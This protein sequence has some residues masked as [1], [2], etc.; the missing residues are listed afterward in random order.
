[1]AKI[2]VLS[3]IAVVLM[4]I[5][6]PIV[7]APSFYKLDFSEVAVLLGGFALGPVAAII[8]E[9]IKILLNLLINGTQTAGVG[10]LANFI[11]G[12]ALV[13]PAV[14][15]YRYKKSF[16]TAII[17]MS[18]GTL[19]FCIIGGLLNAFVL[20][21]VYST[22]YGMP[23]DALISM[24]TKINSFITNIQTFVLLAVT[25]FNIIKSILSSAV[26]IL[27]YKRVSPILQK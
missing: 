8:I 13:L 21:P 3:A 27:I 12:L 25:P 16:K 6:F 5:S 22:V 15:I 17:G 11:M 14:Y 10:E 9:T 23:L 19:S 4:L 18:V 1:M 20:L 2:G 7:I 26:V 24:G